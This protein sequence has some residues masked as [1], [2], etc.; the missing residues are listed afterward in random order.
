[1]TGLCP[2]IF[3]SSY[4]SWTK[5]NL[6]YLVLRNVFWLRSPQRFVKIK[7]WQVN[8]RQLDQ[9]LCEHIMG[10]PGTI[11]GDQWCKQW[12][13]I[14]FDHFASNSAGLGCAYARAKQ[15]INLAQA[16]PV[17]WTLKPIA[18]TFTAHLDSFWF[19]L[20]FA[21]MLRVLLFHVLDSGRKRWAIT[22]VW[23]SVDWLKVT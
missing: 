22:G 7:M 8:T 4:L 17:L 15:S 12:T 23:L 10:P 21:Q 11:F 3:R 6:A 19:I 20:S 14:S 5:P 18:L 2:P 13:R 1:M 16:L 9:R